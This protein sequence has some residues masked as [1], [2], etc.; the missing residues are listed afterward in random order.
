VLAVSGGGR[1]LLFTG[2]LDAATER[3]LVARDGARRACDVLKVPHHGSA[4]ST[5]PEL[6]RAAAPALAVVSAGVRDPYGHPAAP[7]CARLASSGAR[8]LRTD[9]DGAV[10]LS[11]SAH[12]SWRL[13]TPGAPRRLRDDG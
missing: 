12:G 3:V 9:R 7:V 6:A 8:V 10:T 4:G 11:W 13:R 5:S 1:R 2:D